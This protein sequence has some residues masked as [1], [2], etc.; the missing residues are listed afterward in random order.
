M[1]RECAQ[2]TASRCP[3]RWLDE[4]GGYWL[5]SGYAEVRLVL[6]DAT[7]FSSRE[8]AIPRE[9]EAVLTPPIP[10]NVDPPQHDE[11]LR[12]LRRPLRAAVVRDLEPTIRA[13]ARALLA[14]IVARGT[15]EV[16]RDFATPLVSATMWRLLGLPRHDE[17]LVLI[18]AQR[19]LARLPDPSVTAAWERVSSAIAR[20]TTAPEITMRE[21][22]YDSTLE[23][24]LEHYVFDYLQESGRD[25]GLI[26]ELL[27][28]SWKP[29][30][31][32]R[33]SELTNV[34]VGLVGAALGN[35][36][37][38]L[39]SALRHLAADRGTRQALL[40]KRLLAP[41]ITEEILRL[42]PP[43]SPGRLVRR[44]TALQGQTLRVGES[45]LASVAEANRDRTVFRT[46]DRIAIEPRSHPHLTFGVG[47]HRCPGAALARLILRIALEEVHAALPHYL[48]VRLGRE[49]G[50][51]R[52]RAPLVHVWLAAAE[53]PN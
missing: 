23:D 53:D 32:D 45:I 40:D 19:L 44:D 13:T 35:T 28:S 29:Y 46:P 31:G 10:F 1:S 41:R 24:L 37:I 22:F 3:V 38:T 7:R 17:Q 48:T 8:T 5:A 36:V 15:F 18:Q 11:Y 2:A 33:T 14:P 20:V 30:F 12:V 51:S 6:A 9:Q 50:R 26:G 43:V 4:H 52:Q 42:Y 34:V 39:A 16:V 25:Q 21:R 27:R 49:L 47:R